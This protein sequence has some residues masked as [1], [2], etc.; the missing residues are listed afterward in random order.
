M[1]EC[2]FGTN[3]WRLSGFLQV[4]RNEDDAEV[5][6]QPGRGVQDAHLTDER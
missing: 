2:Q 3:L 5:M 1:R 6:G 4:Q